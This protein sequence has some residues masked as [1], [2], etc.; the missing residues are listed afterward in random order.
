MSPRGSRRR[1]GASLQLG[2][3]VPPS[4]PRRCPRRAT[5]SSCPRRRALRRRRQGLGLPGPARQGPHR[6]RLPSWRPLRRALRL[7]GRREG[8]LQARA[9]P[10]PAGT[11]RARAHTIQTPTTRAAAG[12]A[13]PCST[14]GYAPPVAR[15]THP[16]P[17]KMAPGQM[18]A[19]N[20]PDRLSPPSRPPVLSFSSWASG[21]APSAS[22]AVASRRETGAPAKA[23]PAT[24]YSSEKYRSACNGSTS[25]PT[26]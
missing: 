13:P 17:R 12:A 20:V 7:S 23:S 1:V 8:G 6:S 9:R 10:F 5:P 16:T 14:R 2:H 3:V 15:S 24:I 18:G 21:Q 4:G 19:L 26:L 11:R 22:R 25:A